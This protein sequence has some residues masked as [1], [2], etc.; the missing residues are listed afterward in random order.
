M[1]IFI[2]KEIQLSKEGKNR[3]KYVAFVDDEDY[4]YLNQFRWVAHYDGYNYYATRTDPKTKKRISMHRLLMK[5]LKGNQVDHINHFG[6]D[7]QKNNLRNCTP[8]ENQINAVRKKRT[9][10]FIGVSIIS[11][12]KL[13]GRIVAQI[14]INGVKTHIG[15]FNNEVDAAKAY[16]KVAKLH[17]GEFAKQNFK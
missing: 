8:S 12:G 3:G 10:K 16:D 1:G 14:S 11:K 15:V 17:H 13:K 7:N 2:M 5:P 6:L 9:S 4:E